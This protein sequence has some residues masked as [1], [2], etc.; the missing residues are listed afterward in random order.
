MQADVNMHT[1][2]ERNAQDFHD[3]VQQPMNDLKARLLTAV[4]RHKLPLILGA[5]FSIWRQ[6]HDI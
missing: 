1:L 5:N 3:S 2:S 4:Y 6:Q